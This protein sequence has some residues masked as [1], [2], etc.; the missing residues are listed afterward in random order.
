MSVGYQFIASADGSCNGNFLG[1]GADCCSNASVRVDA[2]DPY[3]ILV[4]NGE[5]TSF[6]FGADDGADH[7][8]VV[9]SATNKGAVR[10]ANSAFWGPAHEI[11]RIDGGGSVGFES[12]MF[13]SWDAQR[14]GAPAITLGAGGAAL[15]VRGCDFQTAHPGGQLRAAS[16]AGK[17][18]FTDN[19]VTGALN[20]TNLGARMAIVKDNAPDV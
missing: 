20:V 15:L 17:I 8:E 7:A 16:G 1:I 5:F 13:N 4:T 2:S 11:A 6:S 14:T 3:G 18:I 9:V 10:F 12:C 19:L